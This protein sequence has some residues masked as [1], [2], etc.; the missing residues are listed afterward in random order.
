MSKQVND[1]FE[2][3]A[4]KADSSREM[5]LGNTTFGGTTTDDDTFIN[6]SNDDMFTRK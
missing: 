1:N 2:K 6:K 5:L 4:M 3:A